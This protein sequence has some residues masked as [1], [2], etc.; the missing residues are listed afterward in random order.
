MKECVLFISY[1][2][3]LDPLGGSQIV[4]YLCGIAAHPRKVHVLSFE[5]PARLA[6]HADELRSQLLQRGITW[7][8]VSFTTRFGKAGKVWD[9]VRMYLWG[10]ILV[11]R[12]KVKIVHA[13][14]HSAAQVGMFLKAMFGV[15]LLFDFRGLW[16]DERVDKGGW[17]LARTSHRLQYRYFK[18]AERQLLESADQVVVLTEATVHE[19]ARLGA[20]TTTK[21][22][23]IPCC[24]D[25]EHFS[26]F[27]TQQRA[28][29]R[30]STGIPIDS[31]VL[32]YLGSVGRMYL[33]DRYFRLFELAATARGDVHAYVMTQDLDA[34][35]K[36]IATCVPDSLLSRVHVRAADRRDVPSLIPA[37]DVLVSF[38]QPSYARMAASPTKLA[39]CFAVGIP[40]ICNAGVGDVA[41]QVKALDAG[42]IVDPSS[43]AELALVA[44][45]LDEVSSKGGIRLRNAARGTLG[46]EL[47]ATRYKAVYS[48]I[49]MRNTC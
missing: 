16:V 36:V 4:P 8:P 3:L 21:L 26:L 6:R 2:G 12:E 13:R 40:A 44:G 41:E 30:S 43:D 39:E 14:G 7:T 31:F 1:D 46:L 28:A 32:G 38:V 37:M 15:G 35:K 48:K 47:A 22:T 27:T 34:I 9:F 19:V 49:E 45:N 10:T 5:K 29:A 20:I 17:D 11:A 24:A 25:F 42:V 18:R 33:L 23:V